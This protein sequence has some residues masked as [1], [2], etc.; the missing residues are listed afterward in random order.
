MNTADT[1]NRDDMEAGATDE[2][3]QAE[4]QEKLALEVKID[5]PSTCERHVTV[6]VSRPDIERFFEQEFDELVPKAE[7]PGFRPGRAPRK[8]VVN[9]FKE[10]VADQVKGKLLMAALEQ[11]N[12]ENKLSPI[13]EPDLKVDAIELPD[14]GPMT[15]E[16]DIEVRPEF[17][18][19]EWKGLNLEQPKR[20]ITEADVEQH[21]QRLLARH[22]KLVEHHE[23]AKAGDYV[24]LNMQ[25]TLDGTV[26]SEV[27][28]KT[29]PIK[30][31]LS[32]RDAELAD[33]GSLMAGVKK[34]E[35][36]EARLTISAESEH[37]S[38][39]GKEV[40]AQFEVLKVERLQPPALTP[41]FLN[42]IGGFTDEADLRVAVREELE[43]QHKYR[44]QQ[45]MREQI[46]RQLTAEAR[47]DLPPRLLRRQARREMQRM[48][49]ELQ[50]AGF[51]DEVIQT[52]AN[53]LERNSL[54]S[55]ARALK[56]HFILERLAE[57]HNLDVADGDYDHEI[58]LI[59][60][61]NGISPRRVRARLEKRGEMDALRNQIVERKVIEL[62]TS[63]ALVNEVPYQPPADDTAALDQPVGGKPAAEEIPQ[64][65]HSDEA[66]PLPHQA[67]RG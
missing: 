53:Q 39:Q 41:A 11:I 23:P 10:Q 21:L 36:R 60:E 63:H 12:E 46:T 55:T 44:S 56:E 52:H 33:F 1:E 14:E 19:P 31:K 13:S 24:T 8:L 20:D 29:L 18:M 32:F 54:A 64:A 37:E 51:S 5:S 34:G 30:P 17:T 7:I 2:Q 57:E 9:R 58:E 25:F 3:E 62:I 40:L 50:S 43:R 45:A 26:L 27:S 28:E 48:V 16:F 22:S 4:P 59:A 65:T 38:F 35:R 61:Q 42:E 47:W 67:E 15:F 66:K 49:L 6:V